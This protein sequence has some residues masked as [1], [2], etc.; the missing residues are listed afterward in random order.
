M[1]GK[2]ARRTKAALRAF[3]R[4][5][6]VDVQRYRHTLL[7]VR[8]RLLQELAIDLVVDVGGNQGQYAAQLRTS[9]YRG[10]IVSFEP[11]AE[12]FS[13]LAVRAA[14]DL[15][16][17]VRRVALGELDGKL[18]LNVAANS[19]S[20]SLLPM[21]DRHLEAAPYSH[22]V[23]TE[24]C[25]VVRLDSIAEEILGTARRVFLK[26]DVQGYE[27]SVLR[28]ATAT[29]SRVAVVESELSLVPLYAGQA[30]LPEVVT[31]LQEAGFE[32]VFLERGF[33]DQRT[34]HILQMDGVFLRRGPTGG[35]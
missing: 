18:A 21:L 23:R 29:L 32:L 15:L 5:F 8:G 17:D 16:W 19:A 9:G 10:R 2:V 34:G 25:P 28:G 27:M 6:G 7:A 26:L 12:A 22:Y 33:V 11:L 35:H 30:L 24:E 1:I 13:I 20:S 3:L 4:R 14:A 31:F